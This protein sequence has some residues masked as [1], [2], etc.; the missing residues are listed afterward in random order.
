MNEAKNCPAPAGAP[1][2]AGKTFGIESKPYYIAIDITRTFASA[3]LDAGICPPDEIVADGRLH[4]FHIEGQRRGSQNGAYVLHSD[5]RPSGWFQD[6]VSGVSGKWSASGGGGRRR[7]TLADRQR[8]EADRAARAK[9]IEQ[10]HVEVQAK[11]QRLWAA[12]TPCSEHPYLTRKGVQSHG[13]RIAD[14]TKWLKEPDGWRKIV[15]PGALL[16]PLIDEAGALWNIQAI[17]PEA[18]PELGR[19]KDFLPGRKAGLFFVLGEDTPTLRICE[20]YATG[21]TVCET[22]GDATFVAFD[23]GNLEA[24]ARLVRRHHRGSKIIVMADNDRRTPG[25]PGLSKARAAALAVGGFVSA[26]EFPDGVPGT[27]WNDYAAWRRGVD[28]GR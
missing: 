10:R 15:I 26:P 14:W 19:D 12:A 22:T 21:A 25:N 28:H 18:H 9:D 27:D 24:V 17:F 11:A 3:M 20:G 2:G 8:I 13:L 4:R 5:G 23:A 16:V 1:G 7:L 6:F